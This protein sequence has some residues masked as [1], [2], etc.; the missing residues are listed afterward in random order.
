MRKKIILL[1]A[2]V[3]AFVPIHATTLKDKK[4]ELNSTQQDIKS[5]KEAVSQKKEQKEAIQEEIKKV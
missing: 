3:M 2:M 4:E 1:L 5:K